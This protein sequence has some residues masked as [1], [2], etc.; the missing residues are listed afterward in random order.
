MSKLEKTFMAAA[1]AEEGEFDTAKEVMEGE[2]EETES[3]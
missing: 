1:F 3:D 2:E